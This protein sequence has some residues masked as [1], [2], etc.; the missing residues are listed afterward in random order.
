MSGPKRERRAVDEVGTTG[1][2]EIVHGHDDGRAS[3]RRDEV[4]GVDDVDRPGPTLDP[5]RRGPL[6]QRS[7]ETRRD[8]LGRG[9][10]TGRHHVG[11]LARGRG[12]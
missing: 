1:K 3:G 8:R 4:R 9:S 11:E 5:R 12:T 7:D 6:P 2:R 10:D